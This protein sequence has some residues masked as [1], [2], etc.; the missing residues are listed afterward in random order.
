MTIHDF[1]AVHDRRGTYSTQWDYIQDRFG[2]SGILPFSISDTDFTVPEPILHKII[3]VASKGLYGYTRWNHHDFKGAVTNWFLQRYS[4]S[5]DED[6]VLYSPSVMYSISLLVRLLT[7]KGE[8]VLTLEPMYDSFP[9]TIVGNG[10]RM[11]TSALVWD[12][13]K[14][15][16]DFDEI[17]HLASSCKILLLCS[18]HNPTGRIWTYEELT[19]VLDIC[20]RYNLWLVTDEIHADI[21]LCDRPHISSL[22][23]AS[24]WNK[25][26]TVSSASKTFNTPALG[27]SY[28]II[29][30]AFIRDN[31]INHTRHVDFLNSASLLGMHA[32]ITGYQQCAYYVDELC[33]YIRGNM[34]R[35]YEWLLSSYPQIYFTIPEGTYLAWL[36]V[37]Q[38]GYTSNELQNALVNV[39]EVGIMPGETYGNS[40]QGYL[41]MCLG[42][43]RSKLEEGLSRIAKSLN[44]LREESD[45]QGR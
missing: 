22:S 28:V 27:G 29:P 33:E 44:W 9:G 14:F 25:I 32:T 23:F 4:T 38:L 18:P 40:G 45:V 42:C 35:L 7:K 3:E 1:N 16:I 11:L 43:P 13:V 24:V 34:I 17:E 39:G 36:D 26:I 31:F 15:I 41:R 8:A 20:R 19:R 30:D 37:H 6:W 2:K 12:G 5:L 10:R 21:N